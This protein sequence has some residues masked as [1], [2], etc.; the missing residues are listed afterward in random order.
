MAQPATNAK[1]EEL[2]F[3]VKNDPKSR[4]FFPLAEELRKAGQLAEAEHVLRTGL[5]TH[6]S[7]L[8]AWVSLGRVLRDLKKDADAVETLNRALQIDPGNVVAARL[9]ADAHLSMGNKIEAI[10]KYKLVYALM[11]ADEELKEQIDALDREINPVAAFQPSPAPIP[12]PAPA[13]DSPWAESAPGPAPAPPPEPAPALELQPEPEQGSVFD[14]ETATE[15]P[16]PTMET[17]FEDAMSAS[18]HARAEEATGDSEPMS[19]AH[20]ESPF[21]EPAGDYSVAAL[22]IEGPAGFHISSEPLSADLAAP[23]FGDE[24]LPPLEPSTSTG[25]EWPPQEAAESSS[26]E[27][28]V[29]APSEPVAHPPD[30]LAST[31][32]MADLYAGQGLTDDARQIYQSILA[33]DPDNAA[34]AA[35]LADL[36]RVPEP[37]PAHEEEPASQSSESSGKVRMLESWLAKV[38]RREVGSV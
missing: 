4:L 18:D 9:L 21:E 32:T 35:K 1:I 11:P 12:E 36:D 27:S 26:D 25:D 3:K 17:P 38:S 16:M 29:F 20:E 14:D 5:T 10:K 24:A 15:A 13:D 7:Y 28:D 37:A 33:R 34:V 19:A 22:T 6:A 31:I 23:M 30:D 2:R 8:S